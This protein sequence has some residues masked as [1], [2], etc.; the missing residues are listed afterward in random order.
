MEKSIF[1]RDTGVTVVEVL[2]ELAQGYNCDQI[3]KNIPKLSISDI[4][5]SV[6]FASEVI[7]QHITSEDAIVINGEI[8]LRAHNRKLVDLTEI[9][10]EYPRAYEAWATNEDNQLADLFRRGHGI[11]EIAKQLQR[12]E[13][14]I[15]SRLKK[16][17]LI[18]KKPPGSIS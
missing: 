15:T 8:V 3:V 11:K 12:Q 5:G 13:G 9:R 7:G 4:L 14:A 6:K 2:N 16:L 18:G 1:I 17:E 10:K